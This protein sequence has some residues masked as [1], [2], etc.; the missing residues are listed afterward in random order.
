[1]TKYRNKK[2][3]EKDISSAAF[4]CNVGQEW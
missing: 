1:M 2:A 4:L 3:A